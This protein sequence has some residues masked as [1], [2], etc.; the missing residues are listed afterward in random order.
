MCLAVP[1]T[2]IAMNGE[3]AIVEMD[4]E[5]DRKHTGEEGQSTP[6]WRG[7]AVNSSPSGLVDASIFSRKPYDGRGHKE[8]KD[9]RDSKE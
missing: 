8:R 4:E 3:E 2:I 5:K 1:A 6:S 9:Q 7:L